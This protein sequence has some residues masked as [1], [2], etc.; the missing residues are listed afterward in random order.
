MFQDIGIRLTPRMAN[1]YFAGETLKISG[2]ITDG[3]KK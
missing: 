3:K 2:N 1:T